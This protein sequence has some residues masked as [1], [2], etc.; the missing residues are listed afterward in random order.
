MLFLNQ[1]FRLLLCIGL[2]GIGAATTQSLADTPATAAE[3]VP[4]K[5]LR[6]AT[7]NIANLHHEAGV[8]LRTRAEARDVIDYDRLAALAETRAWDIVALQEIGSPAAARRIFSEDA[9]HLV[10][11]DRY[12]V[13]AENRPPADRD[14]YTA[15]VFSRSTF[16][17]APRTVSFSALAIDHIDIDRDGTPSV[18]PTRSAL[19][20]DLTIGGK[21]VRVMNLHLKSSCHRWSLD[22]VQDQSATSGQ[23]FSS[24]FDCR[25]LVAQ[26][27]ILE[28]WQE[29]QASVGHHTIVLGDFNRRLN[30]QNDRGQ[31][32]DHF[33]TDLNDG[34]PGALSFVKGPEGKDTVCWPDHEDR[35]EDHIDFVIY[36]AAI[37]TDLSVAPATKIS[38]GHE[39]DPR[40]KGR[41][42]QRLSDHCPVEIVLRWRELGKGP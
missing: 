3:T 17:D 33:W 9:Y 25:T 35:Y 38:M 39:Q 19:I 30:M 16:P 20:A 18:R 36:D 42:R 32:I 27:A 40:Y 7:W 15:F 11:S 29:Q 23:P 21:L 4:Q 2:I 41:Q 6:I 10:M 5:Q 37:E 12:E 26:R 34:T 8:A 24:R 28:N 14:I 22:P 1:S 13:G 31:E